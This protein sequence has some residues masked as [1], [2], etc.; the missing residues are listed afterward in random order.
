MDE[1]IVKYNNFYWPKNDGSGITE[2]QA[3]HDSC[4]HHLTVQHPNIPTEIARFVPNKRVV[5]QAGGNVGFYVKQYA[6]LFE[7]VYTFE[8]EP[9]LFHCLN[10]NVTNENVHKFQA[11]LGDN[12][13]PLSVGRFMSDVGSTHVNGEGNIPT[14][15]I[16][17]LNLS[18]CDLIQ[19]DVEGYELKA[20]L[21]AKDT[22]IRC[23]P[24][25]VIENAEVWLYR[26]Q[27]NMNEI[28]QFLYKLGYRQDKTLSNNDILFKYEQNF[29]KIG[30]L[31]WS[32]QVVRTL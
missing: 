23:K 13:K 16:D 19:L 27:T 18:I 17:D 3:S 32:K 25:I 31:I 10:L 12:N 29:S 28:K 20:L 4:C 22:I 24:I 14:Y 9:L 11:C 8:P 26:Y 21:G 7:T 6:E 5:V 2:K 15:K 30:N 1:L